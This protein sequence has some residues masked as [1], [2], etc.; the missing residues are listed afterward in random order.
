MSDMPKSLQRAASLRWIL[1]SAALSLTVAAG[2]LGWFEVVNDGTPAPRAFVWGIAM[3]VWIAW[4]ALSCSV[5]VIQRIT[6][7]ID[8]AVKCIIDAICEKRLSN[9]ADLMEDSNVRSINRR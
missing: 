3:V 2:V 6:K 9:L 8:R 1:L 4:V 7:R 5:L